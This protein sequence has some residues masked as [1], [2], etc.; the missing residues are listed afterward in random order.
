MRE[1][2]HMDALARASE[3]IRFAL[4][5]AAAAIPEPEARSGPTREPPR[6]VGRS[7]RTNGKVTLYIRDGKFEKST[8]LGP[9]RRGDAETMLDLYKLQ[10]GARERGIISPRMVPVAAALAHL[11]EAARPLP[12]ATPMQEAVYAENVTRLASVAAFFKGRVF[13]EIKTRTCKDYVEWRIRQPDARYRPDRT[14]APLAGESSAR[15]DLLMLRRAVRLY[16]EEVLDTR[17][18]EVWIPPMA[19]SRTRWLRR[20][21]VARM[22][23]AARGRVWDPA[24]EG[25]ATETVVDDEGR[26]TTRRVLRSPETMTA[27]KALVRFILVA[28]YTG[29]RNSAIRELTWHAREEGGCVD[30]DNRYIHRRGFGKDPRQGK[31]RAS[32][33]IGRRIAAHLAR[34]RTSDLADGFEAIVHQRDGSPYVASP[35]WLWH[36][37]AADAG[38]GTDVVPHVLRH[39]AATWL[40]IAKVDVRACA[41]LLGMS[42]QTAVR[43]Y[44]QWTLEGQ[45]EAADALAWSGGVK[46][47]TFVE[48]PARPVAPAPAPVAVED[49]PAPAVTLR[50]HPRVDRRRHRQAL[51]NGGVTQRARV[52]YAP[53]GTRLELAKKP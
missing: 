8:R 22:L 4:M 31:K 40:R 35:V 14:D 43:I 48:K 49:R 23:W 2:M 51:R 20:S 9:E 6:L 1:V 32:S 24:T 11:L 7:S 10:K 19:S 46:A 37:T 45:D 33:R 42:V 52:G 47:A 44:G 3:D 39:T 34:W 28:L 27:R 25:W 50:E 21:E 5:T 18:P 15:L 53:A 30:V 13:K 41:D 12:S 36:T 26:E 38:L 16:A 17:P 29:T